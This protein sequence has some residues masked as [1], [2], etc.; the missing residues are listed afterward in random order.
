MEHYKETGRKDTFSGTGS[1][2]LINDE[3]LKG[4][5]NVAYAFNNFCLKITEKLNV[6]QMQKKHNILILK[7]SVP[8]NFSSIKIIPITEAR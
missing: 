4:L 8:G 5:R 3:K 2:S 1:T 6:Q 7:D